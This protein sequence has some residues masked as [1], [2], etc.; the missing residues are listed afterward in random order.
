MF[1]RRG[2]IRGSWY[3][4]KLIIFT[5]S[6]LQYNFERRSLTLTYYPIN[7]FII[8]LGA[9]LKQTNNID[10]ISSLLLLKYISLKKNPI[11]HVDKKI[12]KPVDL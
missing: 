10:Q 7:Y 6:E 1:R 4:H 11:Q 12:N 2:I 9:Q 5:I 3:F 8:R